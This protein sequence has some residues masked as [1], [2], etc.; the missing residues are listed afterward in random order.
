MSIDRLTNDIIVLSAEKVRIPDEIKGVRL[1]EEQKKDLSEGRSIYVEGMTA[2][3]GKSFNTYL[4]FN[5]DKRAIEFR[6]DC[7]K[8]KQHQ[9]QPSEGQRQT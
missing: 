8:Q 3:T 4:Q 1:S 7:P 5:A 6:F 9:R 2:K